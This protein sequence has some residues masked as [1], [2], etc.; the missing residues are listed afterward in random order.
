MFKR[1]LLIGSLSLLAGLTAHG[2]LLFAETFAAPNLAGWENV[3]LAKRSTSYATALDG[4]NHCLRAVALDSSSAFSHKLDFVPPAK[5]KLRWRWKISGVANNGSERELKSFDHAARVFIAF[6]TLVGP[7]RTLNY[8]WANVEKPGTTLEHPRS[9][10]AQMLVL[11]SGNQHAGEWLLEERDVTAD[12]KKVFPDKAMPK[13]VA[14]GLMTDSDSLGG[15][16]EADYADLELM[17]E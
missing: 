3:A 13:I 10:R 14:L 9:S 8:L 16:L 11:Q 6:D 2:K 7:P 15:K 4:T 5:L 12:W 17:A 1:C